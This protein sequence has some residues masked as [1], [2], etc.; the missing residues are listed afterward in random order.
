MDIGL[1]RFHHDFCGVIVICGLLFGISQLVMPFKF[2]VGFLSAS[3][4]LKG[5]FGGFSYELP[6]ESK[7]KRSKFCRPKVAAKISEKPP[8]TVTIVKTT[9]N[10]SPQAPSQY[11]TPRK[12]LDRLSERNHLIPG[13]AG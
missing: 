13:P 4:G 12:L 1:H 5:C 2:Q 10:P 11:Q 9:A 8:K 6:T 3:R 7:M